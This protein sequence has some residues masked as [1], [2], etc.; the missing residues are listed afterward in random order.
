MLALGQLHEGE[1]ELGERVAAYLLA[2][3]EGRDPA[4]KC[5]LEA[6]LMLRGSTAPPPHPNPSPTRGEGLG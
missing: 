6:R 5:E 4:P 3:I 1:S 2:A